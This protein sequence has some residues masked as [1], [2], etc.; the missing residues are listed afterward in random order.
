MLGVGRP[1]RRC[2]ALLPIY[3][4]PPFL[5]LIPAF[6]LLPSFNTCFSPPSFFLVYLAL[7]ILI[8]SPLI[9]LSLSCSPAVHTLPPHSNHAPPPSPFQIV[10]NMSTNCICWNPMEAFNFTTG[11]LCHSAPLQSCICVCVRACVCMY[12]SVCACVSVC[13]C[14]CVCTL[15]LLRPLRLPF[16]ALTICLMFSLSLGRQ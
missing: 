8:R 3:Y 16:T 2:A 15:P 7:N 9:L 14:V 11:L 12:V 13:V 1:L 10:Q 6:P 5:L 4:F